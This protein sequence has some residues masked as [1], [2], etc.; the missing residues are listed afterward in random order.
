MFR[1][2]IKNLIILAK[3]NFYFRV[4]I[5]AA[6][7]LVVIFIF[8]NVFFR[9]Q[10]NDY[11]FTNQTVRFDENRN[12]IQV[13]SPPPD[14]IPASPPPT[15][16]PAP[17]QPP[18]QVSVGGIV[19][20]GNYTWR[21]LDIQDNAA[22]IITERVI[23]TRRFHHT[24]WVSVTWDSSELRQWL[25]GEFLS[26]FSHSERSRIRSINTQT[27][28]NPW[29]GTS[30]G[31][32]VVDSVFLL[33]LD[34]VLQ[35]FGDSGMVGRGINANV[36]SQDSWSIGDPFGIY[37]N[38]VHDNYSEARIALYIR[39]RPGFFPE[40]VWWLRTPSFIDEFE[41]SNGFVLVQ[42]SGF[43]EVRGTGFLTHP[44]GVRPALWL[45][46]VQ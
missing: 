15:P 37:K 46:L 10:T 16:I 21:V 39:D 14:A 13:P 33:S 22:L 30:G 40:S 7:G 3:L 31:N 36:R 45:D 5:S 8:A 9:T 18:A 43:L 2:T 27:S 24:P 6:I 4:A 19:M 41:Q 35:Y 32:N 26:R 28:N 42:A 38:G 1:K 25:N 44:H 29:Y 17:E 11:T 23:E 20:F 12:E 34:E